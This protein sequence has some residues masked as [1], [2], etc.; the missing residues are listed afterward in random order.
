M[1]EIIYA[2]AM[3]TYLS[4]DAAKS[5]VLAGYADKMLAKAIKAIHQ[6]PEY[7]WT[8]DE[9]AS[10]AG[11]SRTTFASRFKEMLSITP[12]NYMTQWRMQ[13][14]RQSLK[15]SDASVIDI[16]EQVGYQSEAAFSR[17]FKKQFGIAPV[18]YRKQ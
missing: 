9:L 2:Q 12:L 16:A 3:R 1:S 15:E 18:A 7:P 5:T 10:V 6:S 8:L 4:S 17:V 11:L 13:I 14:A